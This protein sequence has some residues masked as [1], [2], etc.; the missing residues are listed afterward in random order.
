MTDGIYLKDLIR[1][2]QEDIERAVAERVQEG[3]GV[4]DEQGGPNIKGFLASAAA[5]KLNGVLDKDVT[6][7][8]VQGW[9][10]IRDVR[11]A[12][13]RT[14]K[15]P[16]AME[17]VALGKH[18]QKVTH[19][20]VL[21]FTVGKMPSTEFEFTLELVAQFKS[22][23]IAINGG[24]IRSVAPGEASAIARLKYKEVLLTEKKTPAWKL[25]G[26]MQLP[27]E[28]ILVAS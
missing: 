2:S 27:G 23:K 1:I 8:L 6:E 24:R 14:A 22:V 4:A 3:S 12:A 26:E 11:E 18:E 15:P 5:E 16:G 28:G 19:H 7:S 25:P 13:A 21:M 20:P 9:T 17:V 10:K